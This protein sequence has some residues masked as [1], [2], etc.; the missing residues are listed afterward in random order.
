MDNGE[1][2]LSS[3]F[4]GRTIFNIPEYQRAYAWSYIQLY[5]FLDDLN[6]Q[7]LGRS[8]FL[9]TVLFE[10]KGLEGNY[11][12]IDI[13]DGQQRLTTIIIFMSCLITRLRELCSSEED[14]E[15]LDLLYETYVKHRRQYKLRALE[16]IMI[17]FIA[18]FLKRK[19]VNHLFELQL[20]ADFIKQKSSL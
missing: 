2:K 14:E 19:M 11:E 4:D 1:K 3:L 13:V 20:N 9:G 15:N 7:K 8:Y 18:I 12:I 6:N 5:D 17:F 16:E 10:E